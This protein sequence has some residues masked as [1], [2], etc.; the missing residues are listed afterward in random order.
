[1]EQHQATGAPPA[2]SD[3]PSAPAG[4]PPTMQDFQQKLGPYGRWVNTPEYGLVWVP[5]GVGPG[6][7]PYT[8]GQ[9][10][11]TDAGW[12]FASPAPWGWAAFHYGRW[13]Y[14]PRW[15][16]SWIPGYEWA[17]AWVTWRYGAEFVAWAPLGPVGVGVAY[18]GYPSLWIGVRAPYFWRPL[19]PVYFVPTVRMGVVFHATYYAGVPRRGYYYS[20]PA[21]Y[22]ARV[23]G[24]PVQRMPVRT[25]MAPV[26]PHEAAGWGNGRSREVRQAAPRGRGGGHGHDR[27]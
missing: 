25:V 12:A 6:W 3:Q 11:Y 9:W 17:P 10:V 19:R 27:R 16:W 2:D 1:M 13:V 23:T 20:P 22:V 5:S 4:Q 26:R 21:H 7:R 14:Y 15:G 8:D 18:Y 24:H